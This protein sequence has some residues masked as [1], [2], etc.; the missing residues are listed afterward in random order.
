[1][2]TYIPY[3]LLAAAAAC[4]MALGDTAYTTPVGY[5]NF[6]G[7]AGGNIFIP[8]FVKPAVFTG[9]MTGASSTTLTLAASSLVAGALN[10][11]ASYAT[12]YVEITSG[13]NAG[14]PLDI[15]SN[16]D[17]VITLG[18]DVSLLNLTGTETVTIRP[19][20]TLGNALAGNE[21]ILNPYSDSATF[22]LADGSNVT[23]LYGA[24]GGVGWSSDFATAD[25]S[26]RPMSPG[27]GVVL[28]LLGDIG[29]T[30]SG[31]V[32]STASVAMLTG[33][34]V[35]IVGPMNP[36]VGGSTSLNTTGFADLAAYT[37]SITVYVPG[38]LDTATTYLPL[39]DGTISSDFSSATTDTLMNTTGA[40]VITAADSSVKLNPGFTVAP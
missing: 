2:K 6:D 40:V 24:D 22:Y 19:H 20:V 29:L 12:H 7:K 10:Q 3:S 5:Y 26:D 23:Y 27:T 33:G 21:A 14:V 9:V 16:T 37:D 28:G 31:E 18:D 15:V 8:A 17:S 34:A 30:I 38:P 39:G 32:K 35:S 4:G 13:P 25:G 11:G 1:M 36:L